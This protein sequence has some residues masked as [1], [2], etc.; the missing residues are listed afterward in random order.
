MVATRAGLEATET[1]G[2]RAIS[3]GAAEPKEIGVG[4]IRAWAATVILNHRVRSVKE[5]I[6]I[7]IRIA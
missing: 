4:V 3:A 2:T 6:P 1:I 5:I 7:I